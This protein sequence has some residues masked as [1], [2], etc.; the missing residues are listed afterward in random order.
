MNSAAGDVVR[1]EGVSKTFTTGFFGQEKRQALRNVSF[2]VRKGCS[3]GFLGPNGAGKTTT[4]KILVGLIWPSSG[5]ASVFDLRPSDRHARARFGYLPEN[6]SFPDGLTGN[7]VLRL[8]CHLTGVPRT[9]QGDEIPRVLK[10]VD[11]ADASDL[12]VRKYSKGMIQRLGIAQALVNDPELVILD[13]PMSGLDPVGR[14]EMKDLIVELRRS[15]H[16]ILFS[17]HIIADVEEVCDDAAIIVRGEIVKAGPVADL[18]GTGTRE[19]EVLATG[20]PPDF[21][22]PFSP[23]GTLSRFSLNK[24]SDLH[25]LMEA[26]WTRG[27]RLVSVRPLRYGLEDVFIEAIRTGAGRPTNPPREAGE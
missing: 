21:P 6:P 19:V 13:E 17:T 16:T 25:P 7:E 18:I 9:R 20:V 1:L 2:R 11:L 27:A 14:R 12:T 15:G 24:E 23:A 4:I 10:L 3:F 26:L 5:N 8:V 22:I